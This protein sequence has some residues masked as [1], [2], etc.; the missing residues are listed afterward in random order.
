MML[1]RV[2][3]DIADPSFASALLVKLSEHGVKPV[4]FSINDTN[5]EI[6]SNDLALIEM[7]SVDKYFFS[8]I[9]KVKDRGSSIF[10]LVDRLHKRV[11]KRATE[12]GAD[13]VFTKDSVIKNFK[14]IISFISE[15]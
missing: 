7:G 2:F 9:M 14:E 8:K 4:F 3:L 10:I 13:L 11:Q 5:F 1:S 12:S 6:S 15:K